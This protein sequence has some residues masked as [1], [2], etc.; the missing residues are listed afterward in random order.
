M[1]GLD[2][3]IT[4]LYDKKLIPDWNTGTLSPDHYSALHLATMF[5]KLSTVKLLSICGADLN[6]VGGIDHHTA[7]HQAAKRGLHEFVTALLEGGCKPNELDIHGMTPELLAIEHGHQAVIEILGRHLDALEAKETATQDDST[8]SP[9]SGS[10]SPST[11]DNSSIK[12]FS[13]DSSDTSTN[14]IARSTIPKRPWRLPLHRGPGIRK[15]MTE[16]LSI[17]AINEKECPEELRKMLEEN[18]GKHVES[19]GNPFRRRI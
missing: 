12:S 7:L 8:G 15:I 5:G 1:K 14:T 6:V 11:D 13:S 18:E 2:P 4:F 10:H 9:L 17:Y 19:L 3:A 16:D